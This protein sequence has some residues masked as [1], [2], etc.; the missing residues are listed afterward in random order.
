M[1][2]GYAR[3]S[4]NESKQDISR[5]TKELKDMGVSSSNIF[6][7][8]ESGS[9]TDRPQLNTML[10]KVEQGDTIISTE[11]SRITRSTK[12]LIDIID[13]VKDKRLKLIVGTF[14]V[15]CTSDKLDAMT[16]GMLQMMGVFSELERNIISER[17]KSGMANAKDKGAKIGRPVVTADSIPSVFMKHY[18]MYKDGKINVSDLARLC[19]ISRTTVYKYID[20]MNK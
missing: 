8:Y 4:T 15:D 6:W 3:C 10:N 2:Y 14:K 12:Q 20:I 11:L 13:I 7:E 19:N 5:Q 18:K 1:V 16:L 17:V 9:R